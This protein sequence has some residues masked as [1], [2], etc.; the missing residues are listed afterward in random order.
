MD[1]WEELTD[2]YIE[3]EG[4]H[5]FPDT[6]GTACVSIGGADET[7][8][9]LSAGAGMLPP[10]WGAEDDPD[11]ER[12]D[13]WTEVADL[14]SVVPG[15]LNAAIWGGRLWLKITESAITPTASG[16]DWS[17]LTET[18]MTQPLGAVDENG[19]PTSNSRPVFPGWSVCPKEDAGSL[20]KTASGQ[21]RA[22]VEWCPLCNFNY[23]TA[24]PFW[25]DAHPIWVTVWL[26]VVGDTLVFWTTEGN[27]PG[28]GSDWRRFNSYEQTGREEYTLS[29]WMELDNDMHIGGSTS[30]GTPWQLDGTEPATDTGEDWGETLGT[31][32][33]LN[34]LSEEY[35]GVP[36]ISPPLRLCSMAHCRQAD[37]VQNWSN[38]A[39]IGWTVHPEPPYNV[40]GGRSNLEWVQEMWE[41][42]YIHVNWKIA[43]NDYQRNETHIYRQPWA[44]QYDP[45]SANGRGYYPTG[46]I[47][48]SGS[49]G[50]IWIGS[51]PPV[52]EDDRLSTL[53]CTEAWVAGGLNWGE[54]AEP[55]RTVC[56]WEADTDHGHICLII[57][58][59][60]INDTIC[61]ASC[62]GLR[63]Y[64]P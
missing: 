18:P 24:D 33:N 54:W 60:E 51:G 19:F 55:L 4:D 16:G 53:L 17:E 14:G 38:W 23:Y 6:S 48:G 15:V 41:N 22:D 42:G 58:G 28:K 63:W 64:D 46:R 43:T 45:Q 3:I 31:L 7:G 1:D 32:G 49:L 50:E 59:T 44:Y 52:M 2:P 57:G 35:D 13:N 9:I 40:Q 56:T 11:R 62:F 20:L 39:L 34:A 25:D 36:P 26:V 61:T 10:A 27:A 47:L 29:Q 21:W 30:A 5:D 12:V 8:M 37:G